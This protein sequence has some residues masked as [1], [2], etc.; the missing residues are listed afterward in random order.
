MTC[1]PGRL[2]HRVVVQ[3]KAETKDSIGGTVEAWSTLATLKAKV[4]PKRGREFMVGDRVT[5]RVFY[6]V[7]LRYRSDITT[8][9]RI[10]WE[11]RTL[12][13]R[14]VLDKATDKNWLALECEELA[15]A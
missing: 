15:A 10:T 6:M 14:S 3:Q 5:A 11:G 1:C 7:T 8:K 12:E 2:R 9:M 13:I 4:E